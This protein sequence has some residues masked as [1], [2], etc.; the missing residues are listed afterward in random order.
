VT[1]LS[2]RRITSRPFQHFTPMWFIRP[3]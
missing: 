2:G 3:R 1:T